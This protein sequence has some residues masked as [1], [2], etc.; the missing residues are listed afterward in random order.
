MKPRSCCNV[1]END[2]YRVS[3][4]I[5]LNSLGGLNHGGHQG[6]PHVGFVNMINF[7]TKV[8]LWDTKYVSH[9]DAETNYAALEVFFL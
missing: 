5:L 4:S 7:I 2:I 8:T 3:L 9:F 6:S 1:E